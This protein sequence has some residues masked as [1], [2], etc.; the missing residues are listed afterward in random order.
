M[1]LRRLAL[2]SCVND[3]ASGWS[4]FTWEMARA[5]SRHDE[6]S[7]YLPEDAPPAAAPPCRV[8]YTLPSPAQTLRHPRSLVH[9]LLPSINLGRAEVVHSLTDHPSTVLVAGRLA[10][11][12]RLPHVISAQGTF[13]VSTLNRS[14]RGRWLTQTYRHAAHVTAPSRFTVE[15]L[16]D[17]LGSS[18]PPLSRM[19]NGVCLE[20]FSAPADLRALRQQ[21]GAGPIVLSVGALKPRK[22]QDLVLRAFADI[23]RQWPSARYVLIG[24]DQWQGTLQRLAADLHVPGV[25]FLG[26]VIGEEL[27]KYYQLCD[28]FVLA[29]RLDGASFEG[30]P[31]V[32]LEAGA[33][34]KPVI[35]TRCSGVVD[36]I[37]DGITGLLV[38]PEDVGALTAA[39]A[40]LLEHPARARMM[41]QAG[42]KHARRHAWPRVAEQLSAIY[43]E[44][45]A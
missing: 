19:P 29:P 25:H 10:A 17:Q 11:R 34:G 44:V 37:R 36:A 12:H 39:L 14:V 18:A 31:M 20:R 42:W 24:P 7:L 16:R 5:L 21:F 41:G 13:A 40:Q 1:S 35:G 6:V 4:T 27:V 3:A 38:P 26:P 15:R 9:H 32:Y 45:L 28:L 23:Q 30:F 33:S 8:S 2:L 43:R 22:G